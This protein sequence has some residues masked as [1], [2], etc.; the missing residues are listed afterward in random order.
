MLTFCLG[1]FSNLHAFKS[2]GECWMFAI[3]RI[4]KLGAWKRW[5][6]RMSRLEYIIWV[7]RC[8][9]Q[10]YLIIFSF[11]N[12]FCLTER[13]QETSYPIWRIL[14]MLVRSVSD[15]TSSIHKQRLVDSAD[16]LGVQGRKVSVQG[17]NGLLQ[18]RLWCPLNCITCK[19]DQSLCTF[20]ILVFQ[21]FTCP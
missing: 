6:F 10:H 1:S 20:N 16:E 15:G 2:P 8:L 19:L 17:S 21:L 9:H 4:D 11:S 14:L 13:V 7:I 18:V 12:R 3:V 5:S